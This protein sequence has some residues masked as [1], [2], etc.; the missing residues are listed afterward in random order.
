MELRVVE[1]GFAAVATFVGPGIM[2]YAYR[3]RLSRM[4]SVIFTWYV[5]A[6]ECSSV[7]IFEL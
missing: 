4:S 6:G 5:S 3:W 7:T 2:N 1:E